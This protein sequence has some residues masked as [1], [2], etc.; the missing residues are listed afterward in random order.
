MLEHSIWFSLNKAGVYRK[1]KGV[2]RHVI[3]SMY[4][5]RRRRL[6]WLLDILRNNN[7]TV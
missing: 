2:T 3:L 1:Q 5:Y 4:E 7:V 6:K